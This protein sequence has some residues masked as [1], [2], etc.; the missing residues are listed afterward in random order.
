MQAPERTVRG[1]DLARRTSVRDFLNKTV[2]GRGTCAYDSAVIAGN[3]IGALAFAG[4]LAQSP[5]FEGKVT[6]VAPPVVESRRL[7]NGVTLRGRAVDFMSTAL[8]TTLDD[9][10][11]VMSGSTETPPVCYR[12]TAAMALQRGQSWGF[13]KRG[14]WQNGLSDN[15]PIAYG[16]RNSRVVGGMRELASKLPIEF[17][18]EKVESASHLRSFGAGRHPLLVNATTVPTLIGGEARPPKRMV[19][20]VQAPFIA[21]ERGVSYPLEA[22]TAFAP[23]VRRAGTIDVGY[24]TPF[25]D[26][27]S[28]RSSWYGIYARVVDRNGPFNK[29]AELRIMTEQLFGVAAAMNLVPDDPE[30]TLGR[31]LV[32]ASPWGTV[33]PSA[34]GTL[35]LKR[36]Y[37]GGAPVVYADGIVTSLAGGVVGAEAVIRGVNP[38]EAIRAAL[39]PWHRHNLLWFVELNKIP[40]L[41]ETLM[42]ANPAA[43][44]AYPHTAGMNLWASAA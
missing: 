19:F 24:F 33:A 10:L 8:D 3:G 6:V 9:I 29:D 41:S 31:A 11:E 44:M 16:V 35:E 14:Q 22:E 34:P 15:R 21:P 27:L 17:V 37:S 42:R 36:H 28:P 18:D 40:L 38:D 12:Q 43:A 39:R 25:R 32:P 30:E 5:L 4:W 1:A 23:V 7:I 26:P 13:G 20:G 2:K